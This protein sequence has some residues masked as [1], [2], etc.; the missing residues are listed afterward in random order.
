MVIL[1]KSSN[2]LKY[3]Y[4]NTKINYY[5]NRNET[6][7]YCIRN[8]ANG[9]IYIGSTKRSFASRK[10]RHLNYLRKKMHYNEH[11]QD[12]F[13]Y[14]SEN[15]FSF[16]VLL[17]C[18]PEDCDK[19]EGDFIKLY[20]SNKRNKGYNIQSTVSYKFKYNVSEKHRKENSNRKLERIKLVNGYQ[21]NERGLPKPIKEFDIEG[22]LIKEYDNAI[23]FANENGCTRSNISTILTKRKLIYNNKIILFS[24]DVLGEKD[25]INAKNIVEKRKKQEIEIYDLDDNLIT[26]IIG[27]CN[28][29]RYIN[30]TETAIRQCCIGKRGR[31]GKYKTKYK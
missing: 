29:A 23:I 25:I 20:S 19:Y 7:I 30:T 12:S 13:N 27:T 24:N 18:P 5:V 15:N 17:V 21:S 16:E 11:L 1:I 6:G 2:N 28:A 31:I 3:L 26:T 10:N 4:G 22:N 14:Y 9:K 8:L